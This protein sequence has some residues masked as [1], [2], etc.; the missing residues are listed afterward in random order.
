[1]DYLDEINEDEDFIDEDT[2]LNCC[3]NNKCPQCCTVVMPS[4]ECNSCE[5]EDDCLLSQE[6]Q[7]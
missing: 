5:F 4:N 6:V 1:M 3:K 7:C 2:E